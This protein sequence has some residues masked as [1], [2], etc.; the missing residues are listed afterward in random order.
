M[1]IPDVNRSGPKLY[2]Q[3]PHSFPTDFQVNIQPLCV[4]QNIAVRYLRRIGRQVVLRW[5][6]SRRIQFF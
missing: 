3:R 6:G 5:R 2:L 4:E 1:R